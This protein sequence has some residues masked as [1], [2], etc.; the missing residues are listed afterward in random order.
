MSFG[1]SEKAEA[2]IKEG[3]TGWPEIE[4]ACIFGS[5]AR[6]DFKNGS[7]VDLVVYGEMITPEIVI[8]LSALLNQEL[9]LPYYFDVLHYQALTNEDLKRDIDEE[10]KLFYRARP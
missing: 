5:R 8:C 2:L 4:K 10:G 7:D 6:G 9:P 1:L 3:L